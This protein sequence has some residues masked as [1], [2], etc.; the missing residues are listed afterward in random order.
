MAIGLAAHESE[1]TSRARGLCVHAC[2][3]LASSP[4]SPAPTPLASRD[5]R[6]LSRPRE[7]RK[8]LSYE[9]CITLAP[10]EAPSPTCVYYTSFLYHR[11]GGMRLAISPDF[12]P[13]SG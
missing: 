6:V 7:A 3:R 5:A 12:L 1:D 8:T 2:D 13:M 9:V 10:S 4:A 11:F